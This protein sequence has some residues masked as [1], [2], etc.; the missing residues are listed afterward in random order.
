MRHIIYNARSELASFLFEDF[1]EPDT[2]LIAY[3]EMPA[4]AAGRIGRAVESRFPHL[5]IGLYPDAG[6]RRRLRSIAPTD[7]VLLFAME[8]VNN[9][10][11]VIKYIRASRV[12]VFLWNPV[13][14]LKRDPRDGARQLARLKTL[15][16]SVHT[17]DPEDA[18]SHGLALAPQP[19]RHV[20]VPRGDDVPPTFYFSGVDKGRLGLLREL[21]AAIEHLGMSHR[22]HVVPDKG[23]AY[24]AAEQTHLQG[25]WIPYAQ[26]LSESGQSACLVE[27]VQ[28]HQ[29]GPTL[30]S[31]EALFLQK[32]IVTNRASA[33]D[34]AF[35]DPDRVLVMD[36]ID[37][38]VLRD[39]MRRPF[40]PVAPALL[41]PH[42]IHAWVRQVAPLA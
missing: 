11:S 34:D 32:K 41:A 18:A 37:P 40:R 39:F 42:E 35:Y 29:S 26:N 15:V 9:I 13:A 36:R 27:V 38:T 30:R 5:R 3:S 31:M 12:H 19:F 14:K 2:A 7:V 1:Q 24:G 20:P 23:R 33:R 6:A 28:S 25:G 10:A 22:F 16:S 8:N 21:K 17:F 4:S